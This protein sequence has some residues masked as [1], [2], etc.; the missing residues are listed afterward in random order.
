LRWPLRI[1]GLLMQVLRG[2]DEAGRKSGGVLL[3]RICMIQRPWFTTA[4]IDLLRE[5][6]QAHH[7]QR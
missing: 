1:D 3:L 4:A 6:K 7:E 2:R 5:D